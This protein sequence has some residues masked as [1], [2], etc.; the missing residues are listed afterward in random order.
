[1]LGA[2]ITIDT[3]ALRHNVA[4]L[5][6]AVPEQDVIWMVKANAYGHGADVI[7]PLLPESDCLG[8]SSWDEASA[9]IDLGILPRRLVIMRG[10]L[11]DDECLAMAQ[12]G[13]QSVVH[14]DYQIELL[15]KLESDSGFSAIWVMVDTG[16]HRL[17]FEPEASLAVYQG[18][19]TLAKGRFPIRYMTH[20]ACA[21]EFDSKH[22]ESQ[23]AAFEPMFQSEAYCS[24]LNSA[25]VANYPNAHSHCVRIGLALYGI[26][27]LAEPNELMNQL[28]PVM[29]FTAPVVSVKTIARGERVG[30]GATWQ[31]EKETRLAICAAGYADGYPREINGAS[32]LCHG[33]RCAVVGRVSMGFIAVDVSELQAVAP[34]DRVELWGAGMSINEVASVSDTIPYTLTCHIGS[35]VH[36]F[37]E[38]DHDDSK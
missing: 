30:Y 29:Q 25:G 37:L 36:R 11:D 16:M 7:V 33:K 32:V 12:A 3:D 2:S 4:V 38:E 18:L 26:S 19:K 15:N 9:L 28:R 10:F 1:V 21:D 35:R 34:G 14:A 24:V 5:K 20:M 6:Q 23:L 13:V 27:P 17:G 8:V 22:V 31:A